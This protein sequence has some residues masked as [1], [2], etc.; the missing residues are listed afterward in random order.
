MTYPLVGFMLL[1]F[2]AGVKWSMQGVLTIGLSLSP[3]QNLR[4]RVFGEAPF[5]N[6]T[7]HSWN[8]HPWDALMLCICLAVTGPQHTWYVATHRLHGNRCLGWLSF[9]Y[10]GYSGSGIRSP[11]AVSTV[12]TVCC[13]TSRYPPRDGRI[14]A[15]SYLRAGLGALHWTRACTTPRRKNPVRSRRLLFA[16]VVTVC[17]CSP[18]VCQTWVGRN[19]DQASWSFRGEP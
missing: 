9:P 5:N 16:V 11:T 6:N 18:L 15:G 3:R 1:W 12:R 19:P 17:Y 2:A 10:G 4:G 13:C 14:T 8:A 7:V